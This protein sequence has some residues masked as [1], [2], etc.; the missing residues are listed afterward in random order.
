MQSVDRFGPEKRHAGCRG[1]ALHNMR[2]EEPV[3]RSCFESRYPVFS[4]SIRTG[5]GWLFRGESLSRPHGEG[6][7]PSMCIWNNAGK[8]QYVNSAEREQVAPFF[9]SRLAI[10]KFLLIMARCNC[11]RA[12]FSGIFPLLFY[13]NSSRRCMLRG[14]D[15]L[16]PDFSGKSRWDFL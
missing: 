2:A 6:A 4:S 9:S 16:S 12:I 14:Y 5:W 1:C 10:F 3:I 15:F 8:C 7:S 13:L 11:D